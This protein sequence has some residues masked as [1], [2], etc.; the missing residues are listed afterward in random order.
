MLGGWGNDASARRSVFCNNGVI[1]EPDL[2]ETGLGE[3]GE[4]TRIP[5]AHL[6]EL[7]EALNRSGG[8]LGL[9]AEE[10][11]VSLKT[12]YNKLHQLQEA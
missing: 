9:V 2:I 8:R 12:L 11:G 7:V 10:L 1:Q 5:R 3:G 6:R 4:S